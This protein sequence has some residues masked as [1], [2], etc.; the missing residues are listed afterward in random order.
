VHSRHNTSIV[1][2]SVRC[3]HRALALQ[4]TQ[5]VS[6]QLYPIGRVR[7][8]LDAIDKNGL[9]GSSCIFSLQDLLQMP[10]LSSSANAQAFN[11]L[12]LS[13]MT[14]PVHVCAIALIAQGAPQ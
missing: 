14:S 9:P 3:L 7:E 2:T 6:Q 8:E 10:A 1:P 5:R 13:K 4:G 12:F 11:D